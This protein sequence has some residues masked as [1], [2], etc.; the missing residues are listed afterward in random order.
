MDRDAASVVTVGVWRDEIVDE[1]ERYIAVPALSPAF[2]A[3]WEATGHISEAIAMVSAWIGARP[4]AGMSV[5]VQ[6]LPGRTPLIVVEIEPFGV[7]A[8]GSTVVL[9]GHLDKQPPMS[10]W[11]KAGRGRRSGKGI[12]LRGGGATTLCRLS[13]LARSR[14]CRPPAAATAAASC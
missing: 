13:G 9:Y 2:D 14:R 4:V 11:R 10:G 6:R 3:D 5:E 7:A 8:G 1:L 12:G